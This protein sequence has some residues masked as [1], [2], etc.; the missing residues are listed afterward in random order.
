[1]NK[2]IIML[3]AAILVTV[4]AAKAQ[5][6]V[7]Y[8]G[9]SR[10][11]TSTILGT[12]ADGDTSASYFDVWPTPTVTKPGMGGYFFIFTPTGSDPNTT[13]SMY[14]ER[15]VSPDIDLGANWA[16]ANQWHFCQRIDL[17]KYCKDN[18][19]VIDAGENIF[20][21]PEALIEGSWRYE[22]LILYSNGSDTL[23]WL[24]LYVTDKGAYRR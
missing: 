1:M 6:D 14:V 10:T 23:T 4:S 24:P 20:I 5:Q 17:R 15:Y 8:P 19:G 11:N 2:I 9:K 3:L 13:D 12:D 21:P 18:T 16:S 22:Y 7:A